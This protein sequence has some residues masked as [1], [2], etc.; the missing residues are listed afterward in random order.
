MIDLSAG[1][2]VALLPMLL[3]AMPGI[4]LF[5]VLPAILL[6]ALAA[7]LAAIGAVIAL[8]PYLLARWRRRR[9]PSRPAPRL[10]PSPGSAG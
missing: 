9:L 5:V 4:I 2:G 1:L 10:T 8:P 7:P 6:L 3:L